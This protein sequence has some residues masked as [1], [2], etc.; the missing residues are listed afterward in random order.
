MLNV[1]PKLLN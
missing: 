1:L